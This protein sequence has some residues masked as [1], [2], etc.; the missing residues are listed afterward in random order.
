MKPYVMV[1]PGPVIEWLGLAEDA[2]HAWQI[3]LGWPDDQEI[4][5]QIVRGRF[6]AAAVVSYE[7]AGRRIWPGCA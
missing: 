2:H 5:D 3:A 1:A 4:Q 6:V 7:R